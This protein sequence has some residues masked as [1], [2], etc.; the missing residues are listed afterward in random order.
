MCVKINLVSYPLWRRWQCSRPSTEWNTSAWLIDDLV[1]GCTASVLRAFKRTVTVMTSSYFGPVVHTLILSACHYRLKKIPKRQRRP[2]SEAQIPLL[3]FVV[4]TSRTTNLGLHHLDIKKC[5]RI[6]LS[7][8]KHLS[9]SQCLK[10]LIKHLT[11]KTK[12]PKQLV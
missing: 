11:N 7:L 3:Q 1:R 6:V 8:G 10:F 9:K 12:L 2:F 5:C 4:T